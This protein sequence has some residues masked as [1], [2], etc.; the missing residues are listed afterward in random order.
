MDNIINSPRPDAPREV[1]V[2][3]ARTFCSSNVYSMTIGAFSHAATSPHHYSNN[4]AGL[5]RASR[6]IPK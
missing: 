6:W 5:V 2:F 4:Q 1:Q 3:A